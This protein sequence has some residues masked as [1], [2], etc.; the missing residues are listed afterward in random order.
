MPRP[1]GPAHEVPAANVAAARIAAHKDWLSPDKAPCRRCQRRR[2]SCI[3]C[4]YGA[5]WRWRTKCWMAREPRHRRS[6]E[7]FPRAAGVAAPAVELES[8]SGEPTMSVAPDSYASL[9]SAAQYVRAF[10]GKTFVFKLG[11]EVLEDAGRA[12]RRLRATGGAVE[13]LHQTGARAWRRHGHRRPVREP[14]SAGGEDRGP[15][16]HHRARCWTRPRWCWRATLHTDL[17]A[18]L[19]AAGLPVSGYQRR[20]RRHCSQ[21]TSASRCR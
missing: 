7:P 19:R 8:G 6:R 5:T 13:F 4:R 12:S 17:L 11:G 18:D 3:A 14:A 20:G 10:R 16:R 1:G 21:P 2:F 9:R 15:A